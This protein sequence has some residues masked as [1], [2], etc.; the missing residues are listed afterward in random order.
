MTKGSPLQSGLVLVLGLIPAVLAYLLISMFWLSTLFNYRYPSSGDNTSQKAIPS[1][2]N[3]P[4]TALCVL[5]E[6]R[7]NVS[8][9]DR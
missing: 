3:P 9:D 1:K 2:V 6:V 4:E 5:T 8:G 7:K